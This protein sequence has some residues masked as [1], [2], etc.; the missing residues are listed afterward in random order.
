MICI[1]FLTILPQNSQATRKEYQVATATAEY[2]QY[3]WLA[4]SVIRH[5]SDLNLGCKNGGY[6]RDQNRYSRKT[7]FTRTSYIKYWLSERK[8]HGLQTTGKSQQ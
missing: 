8:K 7:S 5:T 2:W 6:Y 1:P 4:T 3:T